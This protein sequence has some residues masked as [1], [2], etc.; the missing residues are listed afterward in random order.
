MDDGRVLP[1][2]HR[3]NVDEYYRM[4]EAGILEWNSRVELIDGKIIDMAP[5]GMDHGATV[6]GLAKTLILACGDRAI[7]RVQGPV[8]LDLENELQPDFAVLRLRAD[9][10]RVHGHPG[11][12]NILLLVEVSDSSLRFDR[13]V[14]LPLYARAGIVEYWIVNLRDRLVEGFRDPG[15][16]GYATMPTYRPGDSVAL[17]VMPEI[18]VALVRAFE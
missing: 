6:S 16:D 8:R 4:A 7:V 13:T 9:N 11:P 2:R 18:V 3:L 10:Y 15:P 14:K 1:A 12:P 17:A 5:I